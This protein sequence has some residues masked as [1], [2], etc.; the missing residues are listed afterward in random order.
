MLKVLTNCAHPQNEGKR[1]R[2]YKPL[3]KVRELHLWPCVCAKMGNMS[4]DFTKFQILVNPFKLE[5]FKPQSPVV[6]FDPCTVY[7]WFQPGNFVRGENKSHMPNQISIKSELSGV[8]RHYSNKSHSLSTVED[9][10]I[11]TYLYDQLKSSAWL[12]NH[13]EHPR[14][15]FFVTPCKRE[16]IPTQ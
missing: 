3:Y 8:T 14:T 15:I 4:T 2:N 9:T 12:K 11:M 13:P 5:H 10:P 6:F 7:T 16:R 1:D